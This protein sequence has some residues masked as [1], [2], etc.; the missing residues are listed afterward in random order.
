MPP[1]SAKFI[2]QRYKPFFAQRDVQSVWLDIGSLD[3]QLNDPRL[4]CRKELVPKRVEFG[5]RLADLIFGGT[6][7]LRARL[8][9]RCER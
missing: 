8:L 9:F 7:I 5:Q 2:R 3:Q 1:S 6:G 4:L